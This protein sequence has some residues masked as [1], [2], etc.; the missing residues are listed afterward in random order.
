LL[1]RRIQNPLNVATNTLA[2]RSGS[3]PA[4]TVISLTFC[5]FI[6]LVFPAISYQLEHAGLESDL[7]I[8]ALM[9]GRA[10]DA[11]ILREPELWPFMQNELLVVLNDKLAHTAPFSARI[12]T[13]DGASSVLV[14]EHAR[15]VERPSITLS[16]PIYDTGRQVGKVEIVAS[17]RPLLL[18][19]AAVAAMALLFA[20]GLYWA[21]ISLP[22]AALHRAM[23]DLHEETLLAEQANQ[24]K[25]AFLAGMTHELRTPMNGVIGM[26]GLLLDTKLSTEQREYIETIRVSGT[27]LLSVINEVLDFSKIES[28]KMQ[29][30]NQPFELARCIEDVFSMIA[31]TAQ[32]KGLELLYL[33]EN[34]VPAWID[35][36]VSRLRQVLVNL[37]NNGVKFTQHGEIYV[38]VAKVSGGADHLE[39]AFSIRDTGIGIA[40]QKQAELFQ[41]FY[42]V[43]ASTAR[44]YGG[45]GLGLAITSRLVKLMGGSVRVSSELGQGATFHFSIRTQP[46]PAMEVRYSQ[47]DQFA[48]QGKKLLLVDDNETALNILG[49][50]VRRWGLECQTAASPAAALDILRRGT[51]FDAA[52]F[53]YHMPGRDGVQLALETRRVPGREALPLILFSSSDPAQ[54]TV[55]GKGLFAV[56]ITKPLRQS[57]LFEALVEALVGGRSVQSVKP[58]KLTSTE[59]ERLRRSQVRLLVAEDNQINL[60][61]I[62]LMLQKFGYRADVAANGVEALQAMQRQ[63]Y[64]IILM[65]VQMPEMDG[66]EATRR[67][68]Q[69]KNAPQPY[70]I[71]VTAN[72]LDDDRRQYMAAGMDAFL[73]KPYMPDELNTVLSAAM[74]N[75]GLPIPSPAPSHTSGGDM[76]DTPAARN[77][78]ELLNT[79]QARTIVELMQGTDEGGMGDMID[80]MHN[81]LAKF[82]SMV[83]S[84]D[85]AE[86]VAR[87]AHGIK[88]AAQNLGA[89]A[90]GDLYA[91]FEKLAKQG[92]LAGIQH[93]LEQSKLL[94]LQSVQAL[95]SIATT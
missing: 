53:D 6:A 13:T 66:M 7:R 24:A 15:A 95:Q 80:S 83:E 12:V 50:V 70:I 71:A 84:R 37:V 74:D 44:K 20:L 35:G 51:P 90:L 68:R 57:M 18:H 61:L 26:T 41:P 21:A 40:A 94:A 16:E 69:E 85:A 47:S 5:A 4:I 1:G 17:L 82:A 60:R 59:Q 46:V 31:P 89:S 29:L 14:A 76:V 42:Q 39:L 34:E 65:D 32:A 19:T 79:V 33:I 23:R 3:L 25:S 64:D 38:R 8:E 56:R 10:V 91:E 63:A 30:E 87:G 86:S 2:A 22:L 77:A 28:G 58:Q 48:V 62:T 73:A 88:G 52:I 55:G 92:D 78:P 81:E 11:M 45:T 36:D 75:M 72:V 9:R 54:E 49:T 27:S 67:I 93:R 43:D